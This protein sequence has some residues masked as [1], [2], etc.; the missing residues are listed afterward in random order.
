[1]DTSEL[2]SAL[3]STFPLI[4]KFALCRDRHLH[5]LSFK[6]PTCKEENPPPSNAMSVS[7]S[8]PRENDYSEDEICTI[9][10]KGQYRMKRESRSFLQ[11]Q[12]IQKELVLIQTC[13]Y[14]W[15]NHYMISK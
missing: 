15:Q 11:K 8:V 12:R 1:M 13:L 2:K 5:I 3:L 14:P 10:E 9:T 4:Q 6:P 7:E